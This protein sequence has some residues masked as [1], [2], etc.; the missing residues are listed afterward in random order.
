MPYLSDNVPR[1]VAH[2][3]A[4]LTNFLEDCS[5]EDV[6]SFYDVIIE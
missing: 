6:E 3:L 5:E 2:A 1:V 4:S